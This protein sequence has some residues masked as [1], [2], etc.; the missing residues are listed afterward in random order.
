MTNPSGA[1]QPTSVKVGQAKGRPML[2]WV[3]KRPLREVR[4]YPAQL[5]DRFAVNGETS[6]SIDWSDWPA[7]IDHGGLLFHG[8]NKEVLAYLLANGFRG[9]VDLVYIDPPFDSGADYVRRVQL[10]GASGTTRLDGESYTLGEQIQYTD[11]WANDNYLQ[12]MYERLLLLKELLSPT[13]SLYLHCDYRRVYQLG[14]VLDEVFGQ[15]SFRA[16]AVWAYGASARG[17]KAIAGQFARNHDSLLWYS[18]GGGYTYKPVRYERRVAVSEA[19][20]F[21]FRLDVDGR[22]F[23]TAPRG[24]YTDASIARFEGEGRVHRTRSGSIRIKYFLRC[25]GDEIIEDLLLGDVWT[26]I[27]DAMHLPDDEDMDFPTQKPE[28]LLDR[29]IRASSN[30]GDIVLDAFIGSGT[31]AAVAQKLG[32]RWIGA[33]INKGAIQTT[34]KRLFE[35]MREQAAES[36]GQQRLIADTDESSGEPQPAQLG[37]TVYRVNDYD[38]QIQHNEAVNLAVEH[39]GVERMRTDTFFEGTRGKDLVKIVPFDHPLTPLDLQDVEDEVRKRPQEA[40]DILVVA[41]GKELAADAWLAEYA[42]RSPV[43]KIRVIELRTDPKYGGFFEHRPASARVDLERT[44]DGRGKV[45]VRDFMSPSIIERLRGQEG[46]LSPQIDD[47]R[48]MV[49]SVMIDTA[50][51]KETL[52]ISIAGRPRQRLIRIRSAARLGGS[53]RAHDRHAR[54]GGADGPASRISMSIGTPFQ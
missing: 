10:R 11:I 54:R 12:F 2:S 4:T 23:K 20:R 53:R 19:T 3:G 41:L 26:D 29:V 9:K 38:L 5:V 17:A 8:D 35:I 15:G 14:V 21:G 40:R 31:T 48:A 49:D 37:F 13:G 24:D 47:W 45:V 16:E 39:L 18:K 25:E 32:R 33:D 51:D 6:A 50:Y 43:N 36:N 34:E 27:P 52:N 22:W 28:A 7:R 1:R 42:R 46:V 44:G 30:P